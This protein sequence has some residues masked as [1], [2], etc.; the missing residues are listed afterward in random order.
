[1]SLILTS[2]VFI[3]LLYYFI[4]F[5]VAAVDELNMSVMR[6]RLRYEDEPLTAVVWPVS[7]I[8]EIFFAFL[9]R[10]DLDAKLYFIV[11]FILAAIRLTRELGYIL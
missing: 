10:S 9:F 2:P 11:I 8:G 3:N 4:F 1:M 7:L 6:L 5:Q